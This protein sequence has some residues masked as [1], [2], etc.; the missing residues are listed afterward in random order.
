MLSSFSTT[1][2]AL[3]PLIAYRFQAKTLKQNQKYIRLL[4]LLLVPSLAHGQSDSLRLLFV[5]DIMGHAPQISSAE[6]SPGLYDYNHC[7]QF[8]KKEVSEADIAIA[9]LELTLPGKP[10]YSGYPMFKSP[11]ALAEALWNTGFDVLVTANNHSNDGRKKGVINT[12]ETVRKIGFAQTGTF[13]NK[14]DRDLFYPLI[15]YKND[16]KLAF[17]N[18][19]Y[20]TNGVPTDTP[21]IVNLID[22]TLIAQDIQEAKARKPHFIIAVMHWGLEYQ[23]TENKDQRALAIFLLKNGV[24]LV[25]GMHPHVV[26]PVRKEYI[27]GKHNLV[28]YSLGNFIS[29]QQQPNTD[30]GLMLQVDLVKTAQDIKAELYNYQ[31]IPTWRYIHKRASQKPKF[32]VLPFRLLETWKSEFPE[33]NPADLHK[34]KMNLEAVQKRIGQPK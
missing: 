11:D 25:V 5:G 7:F 20:G 26:Q 12:I 16:F 34:M 4:F 31:T 13:L 6:I 21:T 27:N 3:L 29:N 30:V 28:A 23:L 2:I 9:N 32:Y 17:L 1:K 15:I 18:Y 22:T 8:I 10:P 14:L 33:I 24:D 19:T